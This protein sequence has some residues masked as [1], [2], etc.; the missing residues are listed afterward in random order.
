MSRPEH[1]T[2]K[3]PHYRLWW[4]NA[5]FWS[6]LWLFS[7]WNNYQWTRGAGGSFSWNIVLSWSFP[8]YMLMPLTG[9]I[10]IELYHYWKSK[11]Y[12]KQVLSHLLPA[13]FSGFLHQLMLNV[14]YAA[15]NPMATADENM[16]LMEKVA[17]RYD[18]GFL[19]SA[20][21]FLFYWL[22]VGLMFGL[23]LYQKSRKQEM[24]NLA[25]SAELNRARFQ[26]LQNQLQPHFL[27]N[28][29]NSLSMMAR[30][31]K[32]KEVVQMIAMLSDLLRETLKLGETHQIYLS[33]ELEVVN[34]YL[35]VEQLRFRDRLTVTQYVSEEVLNQKVP[36]LMLQ[37]LV[38]NAFRHGIGF[39]EGKAFLEIKASSQDDKLLISISNS[40]PLLPDQWQL[41]EHLGI[42]LSNVISRL[43]LAYE[44]HFEFEIKNLPD[45][46]GVITQIALPLD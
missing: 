17:Q 19:F 8:H 12:V 46:Q 1:L 23:D 34:H 41:D 13:V 15:F 14:F 30:Q 32:Y 11:S 2:I 36:A 3:A 21:G 5:L 42:G 35:S 29:F 40:G 44:N 10:I 27:F 33:K 43:E 6:V 26:T 20:N 9:P 16:G 28:A 24:D 22:C 7:V 18:L 37:P 39:T 38:E 4:W 25:L 31:Q 45:R